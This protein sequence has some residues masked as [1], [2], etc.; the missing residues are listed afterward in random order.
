LKIQQPKS[1]EQTLKDIIVGITH[2]R[3][4]DLKPETT[5]KDL[6]ADSLDLVQMLVSLE[7]TY[8]IEISDKDAE[9]MATFG[10]VADY[11]NRQVTKNK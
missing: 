9:K 3:E 10:D 7:E 1:V 4:E 6:E 2:C 8:K 5:W 11:I